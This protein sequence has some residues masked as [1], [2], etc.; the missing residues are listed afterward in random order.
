MIGKETTADGTRRTGMFFTL[1]SLSV[2]GMEFL[3]AAL[4]TGGNAVMSFLGRAPTI[5]SIEHAD[6]PETGELIG[7]TSVIVETGDGG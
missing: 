5:I 1:E 4:E 3:K 2:P 6:D 7:P